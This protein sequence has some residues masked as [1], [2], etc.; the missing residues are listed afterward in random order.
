MSKQE[1]VARVKNI[2]SDVANVDPESIADEATFED[3][4]LDSLSLLEIGVD[5]DYEYKLG[6]PDEQLSQL[7]S[8][9]EI[10]DLVLA[11][12]DRPAAAGGAA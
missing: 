11:S 10:V 8:I 4:G 7:R 2:I 5:I 12:I 3:L 6:V 1:I 9:P